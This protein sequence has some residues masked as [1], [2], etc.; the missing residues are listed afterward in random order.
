MF[1]SR[2]RLY[3]RA[4]V[5][6]FSMTVRG[7]FEGQIVTQAEQAGAGRGGADSRRSGRDEA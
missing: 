1:I 6:R 2:F 3:P 5:E 4:E 7:Q